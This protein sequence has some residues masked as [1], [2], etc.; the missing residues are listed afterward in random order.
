MPALQWQLADL[1][2]MAAVVARI[3]IATDSPGN[4]IKATAT[5]TPTR[6]TPILT[7]T[8]QSAGIMTA[9]ATTWPGMKIVSALTVAHL[10]GI[11]MATVVVDTMD[12]ETTVTVTETTVIVTEM[13]VIVTEM[14]V[15]ITEMTVIVTQMTVIVTETTVIVTETTV[16]V[17]E[18]TVIVTETTVIVTEM[19]G[20]VTQMTGIV[21]EMT[22]IVTKMIVVVTEK[23]VIVTK[24]TVTEMTGI[25]NKTTNAKSPSEI[26]TIKAAPTPS[27]LTSLL[28]GSQTVLLDAL[29]TDG[30]TEAILFET[31][32]PTL[33]LF[34]L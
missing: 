27:T 19:T 3:A 11:I 5:V 34:Y 26:A 6:T 21:T 16:I 33:H 2:R 31:T 23:I 10:T 20:I 32:Y 24:I 30:G 28:T 22:V 8:N 25:A 7:M 29:A 9:A 15:I 17:T 14:T 12:A 18:T 4:V 1:A 13:T